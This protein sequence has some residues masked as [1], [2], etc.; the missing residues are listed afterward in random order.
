MRKFIKSILPQFIVL[1]IQAL[2]NKNHLKNIDLRYTNKV[3]EEIFSDIYE[4]TWFD[5]NNKK[6]KT[7]KFN[8]GPGSWEPIFVEPYIK[9]LGNFFKNLEK[10]PV[11]IDLGCGDFNIGS[12]LIKYSQ[13]YIGCDVVPSLIEFNK[14]NFFNSKLKFKFLD[15]SKDSIPEGNIVLIRQVLQHLSNKDIEGFLKNLY[16]N[17]P[18]YLIV[19]ETIPREDFIPNLD[20]PTGPF[21]RIARY[22]NSG[23][24]LHESPFDLKYLS[25]DVLCNSNDK[26][27]LVQTICYKLK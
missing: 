19:T 11:I 3:S 18:D 25:M 16:K 8:S 26:D 21:S 14:N 5:E 27:I 17:K 22:I 9:S 13:K 15:I 7:K 12:K 20:Q 2:K 10:K 24:V 23:V 4:K 6:Y 1:K